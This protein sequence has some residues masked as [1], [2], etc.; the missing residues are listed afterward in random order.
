MSSRR[1]ALLALAVGLAAAGLWPAGAQAQKRTVR[2]PL[3]LQDPLAA[4]QDNHDMEA[5]VEALAA[6]TAVAKP[7]A[8][9]PARI[10]VPR[11]GEVL[12]RRAGDDGDRKRGEPWP[13]PRFTDGGNGTVTDH[14]TGLIWLK[15][16]PALA[17]TTWSLALAACN[18]LAAGQAGL[19]DGSRPGDWRLPNVRELE[20]LIDYSRHDPAMP[21]DHPFAGI[22]A[23]V[24][25]S[26]TT[27][28]DAPPTHYAGP[29]IN[30]ARAVNFADGRVRD[31][32][33]TLSAR[34]W[35]V[36]SPSPEEGRVA[37]SPPAPVPRTGQLRSW[38]A[39]D[40]GDHQQGRPWP[41]PRFTDN[42]DGTVADNLTGLVWLK[43]HS[44]MKL[45]SWEEAVDRC[46]ELS[47]GQA[48]LSDGSRPGDWRLPNVRE[49]QS[50]LDYARRD[51]ALPAGHPFVKPSPSSHWTSTPVPHK[52]NAGYRLGVRDGGT[53]YSGNIGHDLIWP[54][55]GGR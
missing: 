35:P 8:F 39:G 21:P 4:E 38:A 6:E 36:R 54:V 24:F 25:W 30:A 20:S 52:E 41:E 50:L 34:L 33:K 46:N 23:V 18:E 9:A 5:M 1:S 29:I 47:D 19:S 37:A 42:G 32:E 2:P 40:D 28:L 53:G 14:L 45:G 49:F 31:C 3:E 44:S 51:P 15:E 11:T 10:P 16:P 13:E 48:G 7:S 43:D 22:E 12:S 27:M 55:R 26:S 17:A